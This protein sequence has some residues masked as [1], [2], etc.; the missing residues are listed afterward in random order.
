MA[1]T[2]RSEPPNTTH[3]EKNRTEAIEAFNINN[4]RKITKERERDT[5]TGHHWRKG[6]KKY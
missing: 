1:T 4:K 5:E 6:K 2:D 3:T